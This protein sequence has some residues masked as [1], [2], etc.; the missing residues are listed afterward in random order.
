[1][2]S[3]SVEQCEVSDMGKMPT[4]AGGSDQNASHLKTELSNTT[5][6]DDKELAKIQTF[7]LDALA[8]L[9]LILEADSERSVMT[10]WLTALR[11]QWHELA[12]PMPKFLTWG[13]KRSSLRSTRH[14]CPLWR[15]ILTFK[16]Q[17]PPYLAQSFPRSLRN[18]WTKSKQCRSPW[19]LGKSKYLFFKEAPKE[20]GRG[21]IQPEV[22]EGWRSPTV[23]KRVSGQAVLPQED[24]PTRTCQQINPDQKQ[25]LGK[26]SLQDYLRWVA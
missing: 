15:M 18:W 19:L 5:K 4:P 11:Q 3:E 21:G 10:K 9:T 2:H 17:H 13:D 16:T 26:N 22:R 14:S 1:M 8:P 7:M 20:G 25:V 12:M 6:S 24:P 23:L